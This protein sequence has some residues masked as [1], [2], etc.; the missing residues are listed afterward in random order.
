MIARSSRPV[1]YRFKKAIPR[2]A[3]GK[4]LR[5]QAKKNAV[6]DLKKGRLTRISKGSDE[7]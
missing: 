2:T 5:R 6:A 7:E 3:S 1:Y 4:K